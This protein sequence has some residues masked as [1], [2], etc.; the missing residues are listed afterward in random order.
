M[1]GFFLVAYCA[2]ASAQSIANSENKAL[3]N[4]SHPLVRILFGGI[5]CG[6]LGMTFFVG[7]YF[8]YVFNGRGI[9]VFWL[10]AKLCQTL[11]KFFLMSILLLV[12]QGRCISRVMSTDDAWRVCKLLGPF[13]LICFT[14]EVWGDFAQSRTYT[15]DFVYGTRAGTALVLVDLCLLMVYAINLQASYHSEKNHVKR[16]FYRVWGSLYGGWF[17][18]LPASVCLAHV[19]A[20]WVRFKIVLFVSSSAHGAAYA[21]LVAGL[22]PTKH[23]S[24]FALDATELVAFDC[25]LD[26]QPL[27]YG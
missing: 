5:A 17:L 9:L 7:H 21:A 25:G 14:L 11:S 10:L 2:L 15:T 23:R 26:Y 27:V 16:Y 24:Y 4:S 3:G 6:A 18:V 12:S 22:W 20:P 8:T 13:M 19:L 1:C